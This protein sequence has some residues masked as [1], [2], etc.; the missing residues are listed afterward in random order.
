MQ[1]AREIWTDERLDDF[2]RDVD[3]RFDGVDRRFDKLEHRM[4]GGFARVDGELLAIHQRID[5]LQRTL[6]Q[7]GGGVLAALIGLIATQL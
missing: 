3:R 4:D 2:R 5:A 1:P 7:L 6:M